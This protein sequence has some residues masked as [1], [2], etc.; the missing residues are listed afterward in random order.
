MADNRVNFFHGPSNKIAEKVA[1]GTIDG[2]DFVVGSDNDALYYVDVDHSV[3]ELGSSKAKESHTVNLG[4]GGS[5]GGLKTGDV[6]DA[7]TT[8]DELIKKIMTKRVAPVY[9]KPTVTLKVSS[10]SQPGNY[11]VGQTISANMTAAFTQNDAGAMSKISIKKSGQE[12][13]ALEGVSTPLSGVQEIAIPDGSVA[14]TAVAEYAEGTVKKD[15]LEDESPEGH[16]AAGSITSAALTYVGKR[17]AFFGAGAG[18]AEAATSANVRALAGK[19]LA[20]VNGTVFSFTVPT[21]SQ[22][23]RFAYPA[24]LED[25]KEVQYVDLGDKGMASSFVKSAVSVEGANG[26]AGVDYKV[27]TYQLASATKAAMTFQVTI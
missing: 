13:A 5:V 11:E 19:K 10:G 1:D 8:I 18:E 22:Y 20:P 7:G 4:T 24:S 21:G 23:I 14:F 17:N 26:A 16:I 3:H 12:A 15:N 2:S 25:V 6:I 27:Y 9:T